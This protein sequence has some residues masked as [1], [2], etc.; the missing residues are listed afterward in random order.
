MLLSAAPVAA[1]VSNPI[2]TPFLG[3]ESVRLFEGNT[4]LVR[5]V[6]LWRDSTGLV[7]VDRKTRDTVHIP[8]FQITRAE[9]Q[10]GS[11]RRGGSA[12]GNGAAVGAVVGGIVLGLMIAS[13]GD[14][15]D[16]A[17][18]LAVGGLFAVA[19][20]GIGT[21]IGAV[22]SFTPTDTWV[23][24]DPAAVPLQTSSVPG[25]TERYAISIS[26]WLS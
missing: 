7:V 23:P 15:E 19:A 11:H 10:R 2:V 6:L 5:G 25:M 17:I 12:V 18:G 4:E 21:A 3:S 26:T 14:G 24:F 16:R 9:V 8:L 1:Q 13:P 22:V 20:T